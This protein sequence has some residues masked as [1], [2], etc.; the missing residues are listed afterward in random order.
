MRRK[1]GECTPSSLRVEAAE[2][3]QPLDARKKNRAVV[4]KEYLDHLREGT[5]L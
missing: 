4:F 2:I 5:E 3:L 1:T